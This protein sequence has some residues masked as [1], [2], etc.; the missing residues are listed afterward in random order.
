MRPECERFR[1]RFSDYLDGEL[2]ERERREVDGH[3]SGCAQCR[4]ELALLRRTVEAV[5]NAGAPAAPAGFADRVLDAIRRESAPREPI[6]VA[7]WGRLVPVA[8]MFLLVVGLL[9]GV[10]RTLA[11]AARVRPGGLAVSLRN[12]ADMARAPAVRQAEQRPHEKATGELP[13]RTA[14]GRAAARRAEEERFRQAETNGVA[15]AS[16]LGAGESKRAK[17]QVSEKVAG[18]PLHAQPV[19]LGPGAAPGRRRRAIA[20]EAEEAA[21]PPALSWRIEGV[22]GSVAAGA[23]AGGR[24]LVFTQSGVPAPPE[25]PAPPE[26]VLALSSE[27][28]M[29]LTRGV[30]AAANRAGVPATLVL[31]G[32]GAEVEI[33]L[34][35]PADRCGELTGEFNRLASQ[36]AR[37]PRAAVAAR[38]ESA[39]RV[40][41]AEARRPPEPTGVGGAKDRGEG[42]GRRIRLLIKISRPA[43]Q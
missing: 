39:S 28:P 36:E 32:P 25:F 43:R 5:R 10:H 29:R 12:A 9:F 11:P 8:A 7:I 37:P 15:R 34:N 27:D 13:G 30:V 31:G 23:T 4:A 19:R 20:M 16:G 3:L 41:A 1:G 22:K 35:V 33:Y 24:R 26:R 18:A 21:A 6:A 14:T 40:L 2:G 17:A 42:T 38:A